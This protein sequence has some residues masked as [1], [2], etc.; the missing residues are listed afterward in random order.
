[1]VKQSSIIIVLVLS[2]VILLLATPLAYFTLLAPESESIP[3]GSYPLSDNQIRES[4]PNLPSAQEYVD[5]GDYTSIDTKGWIVLPNSTA[6]KIYLQSPPRYWDNCTGTRVIEN[7]T[8][9]NVPSSLS[10]IPRY[11]RIYLQLNETI[12]VLVPQPDLL[13]TVNPPKL[14]QESDGFLGT[15][16]PQGYGYAAVATIALTIASGGAFLVFTRWRN[17]LQSKKT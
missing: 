2:E 13:D 8:E 9:I 6:N 15:N 14:P 11:Y 7:A 5:S 4:W 17:R 16:M 1:M 3:R 10:S 12:W